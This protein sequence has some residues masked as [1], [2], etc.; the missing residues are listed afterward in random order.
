MGGTSNIA[1]EPARPDPI[2]P[3][4][5]NAL[6]LMG[7]VQTRLG[8]TGEALASLQRAIELAPESPDAHYH[9]GMLQL[10]SSEVAD[11]IGYLERAVALNPSQAD[12]HYNLGVAIFMT[13]QPAGAVR[14]INRALELK[15]DD[16]VAQGFLR[17]VRDAI[18]ENNENGDDN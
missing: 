6:V 1:P 3:L 18:G 10:Q 8:Q 11:A 14:H 4:L 17:V 12:Y 7:V 16:P 13:G 2:V 9:L 5:H 15:P